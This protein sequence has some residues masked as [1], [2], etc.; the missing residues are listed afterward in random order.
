MAMMSRRMAV[1]SGCW[2]A[3]DRA[4]CGSW[5]AT[6][7]CLGVAQPSAAVDCQP[8]SK[9]SFLPDRPQI[10]PPSA[11]EKIR[12]HREGRIRNDGRQTSRSC[13]GVCQHRGVFSRRRMRTLTLRMYG[14]LYLDSAASTYTFIR[15]WVVHRRAQGKKT[16]DRFPDLA[17]SHHHHERSSHSPRGAAGPTPKGPRMASGIA[18]S[19]PGYHHPGGTSIH[20]HGRSASD[21]QHRVSRQHPPLVERA[22][23]FRRDEF[24]GIHSDNPSAAFANREAPCASLSARPFPLSRNSPS[25]VRQTSA[26]DSRHQAQKSGLRGLAG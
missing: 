20:A 18:G 2:P 15:T 11:L 26:R 5:F 25:F 21:T 23:V 4:W 8:L 14:H 17:A 22:A 24:R 1:S 16:R 19:P 6:S 9:S 10:R 13:A 7:F 12:P 3:K